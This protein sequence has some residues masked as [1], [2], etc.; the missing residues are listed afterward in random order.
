MRAGVDVAAIVDAR[1]DADLAGALPQ[2]ARDADLLILTQ[3]VV[4]VARG[5]AASLE[6]RRR[7]L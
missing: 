7:A 3:R 6:C 2:R 4:A 5:G 1:A